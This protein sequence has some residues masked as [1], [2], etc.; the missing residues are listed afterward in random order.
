M[1]QTEEQ[2][3]AIIQSIKNF[4]GGLYL[5]IINLSKGTMLLFI[6][7]LKGVVKGF[8]KNYD[9]IYALHEDQLKK[10]IKISFEKFD[11]LGVFK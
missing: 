8:D 4:R 5:G 1:Q 2:R 7:A 10:A 3:I 9:L 11:S 6:K